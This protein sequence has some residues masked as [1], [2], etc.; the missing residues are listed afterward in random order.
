[1]QGLQIGG[2]HV[3][4][5]EES[6]PAWVLPSITLEVFNSYLCLGSSLKDATLIGLW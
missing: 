1:M 6:F 5:V 2:L 3:L 4:P